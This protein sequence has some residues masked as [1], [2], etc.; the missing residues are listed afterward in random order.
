LF[1]NLTAAG[2]QFHSFSTFK[3]MSYH[4]RPVYQ[5]ILILFSFC[6]II[7]YLMTCLVPFVNTAENWFIALPGLIFPILFFVLLF[8]ALMWALLKSRMVW[9]CLVTLILGIQQITSVFSFHFPQKFLYEKNAN[10]LRVF[11]WNVMAWDQGNEQENIEQGGHALR[12]F[13]MQEVKDKKP[14]VLCFEEFFESKDSSVFGSNIHLLSQIGF[15]YYYFPNKNEQTET[16]AGLAIFSKYPIIDTA[17][18]SLNLNGKGAQL[19]YADIKVQEK[20]IRIFTTHLIPIQFANWE[21]RRV[22]NQEIYGEARSGSYRNIFK[23]V[24]R[25]YEI[26]YYQ[27]QL[28]GSKIAESPY[29]AVVCGDF[30]DVPNSATYFNIKGN[31]QDAFLKKGSGTGRTTRASFGLIS[32]TLRIDYILASRDFKVKQFEIS[33]VPY[34]DHFPL[35]ADLGY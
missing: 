19:I 18:F 8:L 24:I 35:I 5:K 1:Q 13:M 30:N 3:T 27:S 4:Q 10:T 28:A 34:S 16:Q 9:I 26:R 14:D 7:P 15:P 12:P 17:A 22:L 6:V 32:P 21:N 29:P 2:F 11:Q 31:L 33:H 25:G 20:K 23:K